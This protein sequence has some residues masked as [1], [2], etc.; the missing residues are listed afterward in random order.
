MRKSLTIT[1]ERLEDGRIAA[2]FQSGKDARE[3]FI[4]VAP[5]KWVL[6]YGCTLHEPYAKV[7]EDLLDKAV[8]GEE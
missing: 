8:H 6:A 3:R 2:F 1:I 4:R 7:C 5:A